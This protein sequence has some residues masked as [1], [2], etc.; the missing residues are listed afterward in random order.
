MKPSSLA[1]IPSWRNVVA[2][3]VLDRSSGVNHVLVTMALLSIVLSAQSGCKSTPKYLAE[4]DSV[5][6]NQVED[7]HEAYREG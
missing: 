7:A 4:P 6:V 1:R 5:L 3:R 2:R